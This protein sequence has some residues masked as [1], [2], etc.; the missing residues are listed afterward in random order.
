MYI[1]TGGSN[2][3]VSIT[4]DYSTST[5]FTIKSE[6]L[7]K[8]YW[9]LDSVVKAYRDTQTSLPL[10]LRVDIFDNQDYDIDYIKVKPL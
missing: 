10:G 9:Y 1:D 5:V 2:R 7:H 8:I 4:T 6:N 3:D